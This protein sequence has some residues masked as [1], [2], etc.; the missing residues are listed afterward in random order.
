MQL[1][2]RLSSTT[3]GDVLGT[4]HRG[5]ATGCLELV[6]TRGEARSHRIHL[7]GGLVMRVESHAPV[8][9]LGEL[10]RKR[11]LV[12]ARALA[13]L[14]LR[15]SAGDTRRAGD[16]LKDDGGVPPELIHEALRE[17]LQAKLEPLFRLDDALLRFRPL[18]YTVQGET[19]PLPPAA[20]LEGRPRARGRRAA[21][22]AQPRPA[23]SQPSYTRVD[24]AR[25]AALRELGL[26]EAADVDT[27]RRA[28]RRLAGK[29]HPDRFT[30]ASDEV[31]AESMRAL[32]RLSAAYHLLTA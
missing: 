20:F 25:A 17:Q 28:F 9:K 7:L 29:L 32:T 30:N 13:R 19:T 26:A 1:P 16:I 10:M 4:L 5:R 2:G 11:G 12:G 8:P 24:P 18:H 14:V 27:V 21:P 23:A 6:E 3:L 31:R 15:L 22:P